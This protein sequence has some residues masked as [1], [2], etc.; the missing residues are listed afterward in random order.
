MSVEAL[1]AERSED[2]WGG[3]RNGRRVTRRIGAYRDAARRV[4]DAGGG[5]W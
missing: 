2:S 3:A 5:I 4:C 1:M